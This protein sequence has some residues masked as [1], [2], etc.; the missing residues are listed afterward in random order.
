MPINRSNTMKLQQIYSTCCEKITTKW[1]GNLLS[2]TLVYTSVL[3]VTHELP[4]RWWR[5]IYTAIIVSPDS[6]HV[7]KMGFG[8]LAAIICSLIG[9]RFSGKPVLMWFIAYVKAHVFT[10]FPML[11]GL[12][13]FAFW[14]TPSVTAVVYAILII[15]MAIFFETFPLY[16]SRR[17]KGVY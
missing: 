1:G 16:A 14:L 8:L 15:L 4:E 3:I 17:L 5:I 11:L 7:T 10:P 12:C 2:S 6:V 9:E 13:G